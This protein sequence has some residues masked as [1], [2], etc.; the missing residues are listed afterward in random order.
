MGADARADGINVLV[1]APHRH[2]RAGTGLAGD[3]ADLDRAVVDLGHFELEQALDKAGV[4]AGDDDLRA[5]GL[6]AH[7]DKIDLDALTLDQLFALDLLAGEQQR[8][9]RLRA[10]ADAQGSVAR[11]RIDARDDT[12]EDLV[13]LGVVFVVDHAALGLAQALND[14]LLAVARGD[15]A[16]L[17]VV[18]REVDDVAN[19]ILG[20]NGLGFVK[21]HLRAGVL[22]LFD[23][24]LLH[25]HFQLALALVHVDHHVFHALVVALV[26]GGERLNDLIHHK[27]LGNAAFLF[28]H[29]KCCEDFI[30]FHG[31]A[32]YSLSSK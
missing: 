26:G 3:G 15:S 13:L 22:D 1:V 7:V 27:G 2:L 6:A 9:R 14:D 23:D 8:V 19:I 12:G 5:A 29:R 30:T 31:S 24:F 4:R 10:R 21:A 18:D 11:A 25:E 17:D 32:P 28:Q 20:G 16:E